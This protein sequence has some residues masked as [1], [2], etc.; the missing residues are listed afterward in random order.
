MI[1]RHNLKKFARKYLPPA[2]R[3]GLRRGYD[4][5]LDTIDEVL[6]RRPALCPP[7]RLMFVGGRK[8]FH[9]VGEDFLKHFID[10]GGLKPEHR[11]LDIGCGVGR[12]AIPLTGYLGGGGQYDG[13]DVVPGGIAWCEKNISI[14]FP[15]FRFELADIYN[16]EYNPRGKLA[17]SAFRFPYHRETFD[18]IFAT[19][20][21]THMYPDDMAW[22]FSEIRRVLKKG[23][24]CLLTFFILNGDTRRL[25]AAGK[26]GV[27]FQY[28]G[29]GFYTSNVLTPEAAIAYEESRLRQI[30]ESK[31]L[32]IQDPIHWG[33]WRGRKPALSYQD[34]VVAVKNSE[35]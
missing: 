12:I 31:G 21:F 26:S 4:L 29:Q 22:Y 3:T 10:L 20:V 13:F 1:A 32:S 7:R 23:G 14:P 19:S 24:R 16:K 25:M 6:G 28:R 17:A 35:V 34:L 15:H 8:D 27:N 9:K 18:F 2:V 30:H 33:F 11:V 5:C